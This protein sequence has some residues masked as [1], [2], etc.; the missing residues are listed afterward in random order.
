[1]SVGPGDSLPMGDEEFNEDEIDWEELMSELEEGPTFRVTIAGPRL[2]LI[3][4]FPSLIPRNCPAGNLFRPR[5][6]AGVTIAD[7]TVEQAEA[8]RELSVTY[9]VDGGGVAA[10]RLLIRWA[11]LV[12][13]TRVW[14]PDRV[15]EPATPTA[16]G[17]ARVECPSCGADWEDSSAEFWAQ[18]HSDG[19]F[20]NS[21]P[22]CAGDLP[23]WWLVP[24]RAK[25][26]RGPARGASATARPEAARRS[27]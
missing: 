13:Y 12:G 10:E 8:G 21:C 7:L 3:R 4:W 19:H 16:L 24:A 23:Q 17:R 1:M 18:V 14:L 15:V 5:E 20:P 2:T 27:R 26:R 9:L 22:L 6:Q 25:R 11:G